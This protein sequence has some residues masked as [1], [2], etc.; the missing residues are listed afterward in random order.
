MIAQRY[1]NVKHYMDAKYYHV[2][3]YTR[4]KEAFW[5]IVSLQYGQLYK[6]TLSHGHFVFVMLT[7]TESVWLLLI[8]V[9]HTAYSRD[10]QLT[11]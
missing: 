8:Y 10:F 3:L 1:Q 9:E 5:E 4:R 11:V 2:L 7:Q 6:W